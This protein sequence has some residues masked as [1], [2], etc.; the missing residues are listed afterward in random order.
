MYKGK[1]DKDLPELP[2]KMLKSDL[3]YPKNSLQNDKKRVVHRF[4]MYH[5]ERFGWV[6]PTLHIRNASRRSANPNPARTYAIAIRD[7]AICRVGLGPHVT[8][9]VTVYVRKEREEVLKGFL[10]IMHEGEV[11]A[12]EI[13]DQISTRRA[14]GSFFRS[15]R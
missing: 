6:I 1:D 7:R 11:R 14:V 12:N 8:H 2:G 13:R 15:L 5:T 4:Q 10:D 3:T 9:V